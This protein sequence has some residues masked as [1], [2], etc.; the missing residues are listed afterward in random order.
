MRHL[1]SGGGGEGSG[2]RPSRPA[3]RL[4][5]LIGQAGVI[6]AL[7]DAVAVATELD[8][9]MGHTLLEGP[10]GMGDAGLRCRL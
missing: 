1:R 9:P 4:V 2:T 7:K 3:L 8:E 10:A 6:E 5:E